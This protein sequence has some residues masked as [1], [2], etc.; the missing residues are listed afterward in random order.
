MARPAALAD[1][2]QA[3][4]RVE[5]DP[6]GGASEVDQLDAAVAQWRTELQAA[7][8]DRKAILASF[9]RGKAAL[10]ELRDLVARSG[11]AFAEA[12]EQ[13]ADPVGLVPPTGA[14]AAEALDTWLRTLEQT[15]AAGRFAAVKVGLA[16]WEQACGERLAEERAGYARNSAA[17]DERTELQGRFRALCAKADALRS[18]GLALGEAAE[19]TARQGKRV[20]DAVPFD[21]PA[22]RRVV[23]AFEAALSAAR[24]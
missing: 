10:A 18:R 11:V 13:I 17:L 7:D 15:A 14:E 21:L 22:A 3:L 1:A 2:S 8:A 23:A 24:K 9:E 5:S 16:K 6:L 12:R 4:S 19:A 20:L